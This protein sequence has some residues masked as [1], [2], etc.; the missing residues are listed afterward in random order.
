MRGKEKKRK[1]CTN[2]LRDPTMSLVVQ[3]KYS[4]SSK[5]KTFKTGPKP[6]G[7]TPNTEEVLHFS[8]L[9]YSKR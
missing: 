9:L 6:Y 3:P 7:I 5:R 4:S 8:G 1:K 2:R